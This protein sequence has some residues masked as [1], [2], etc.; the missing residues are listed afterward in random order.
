MGLVLL[1]L[2][3]ACFLLWTGVLLILRASGSPTRDGIG[4]ALAQGRPTEPGQLGFEVESWTLTTADG[5]D[6]PGWTLTT[7]VDG[8]TVVWLH[9]WS[10]SQLGLLP[11]LGGWGAWCG[12][13]VTMDLRGH[14]D[15]PGACSLG[16]A[17]ADDLRRL[18]HR[19]V[20]GPVV[21]AGEGLGAVLAINAVASGV[22]EP[23]GVFALDP[24]VHG[25]ERFRAALR[26]SGYHV[27]P[28]ADLA[29]I[30]LWLRDRSPIDLSWPASPGV[31]VLARFTDG[32]ADALREHVPNTA[33]LRIET[34]DDTGLDDA[35]RVDSPWW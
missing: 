19:H 26:E 25:S 16:L 9:D 14:G 23:L 33:S 24:F 35:G 2:L 3:A 31:P 32:G 10:G 20:D 18:L 30:M 13:I 8:P 12:R 22:I 21:L 15:A 7:G 27:F 6:L 17:E 1:L 29:L 11:R 34:Y 5:L 28:A 4:R